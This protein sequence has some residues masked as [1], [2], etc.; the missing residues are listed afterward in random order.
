M[1]ILC[2]QVSL[3]ELSAY[4]RAHRR[5][6]QTGMETAIVTHHTTT[7]GFIVSLDIFAT[8]PTDAVTQMPLRDLQLWLL[9]NQY[10][11]TEGI[12]DGLTLTWHKR[13]V[14]AFVHPRYATNCLLPIDRTLTYS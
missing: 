14:L 2:R 12:M 7:L 11:W 3:R 8:L 4:A 9:Q 1:T 13:E 10:G 5:R 6:W